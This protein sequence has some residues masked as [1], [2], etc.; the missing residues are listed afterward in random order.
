MVLSTIVLYL[1]GEKMFK[2]TILIFAL[3]NASFCYAEIDSKSSE[4]LFEKKTEVPYRYTITDEDMKLIVANPTYKTITMT[5]GTET[6][7]VPKIELRKIYRQGTLDNGQTWNVIIQEIQ[8]DKFQ[9]NGINS[10]G[11]N[12]SGICGKLYECFPLI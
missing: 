8:P 7:R 6:V 4:V 10:N 2:K 3:L 11:E 9:I 1:I 12:L 5:S